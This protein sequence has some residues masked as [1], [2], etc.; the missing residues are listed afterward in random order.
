MIIKWK[1]FKIYDIVIY[2]DSEPYFKKII[3]VKYSTKGHRKD[4]FVHKKSKLQQTCLECFDTCNNGN[5]KKNLNM[6]PPH[7]PLPT[8]CPSTLNST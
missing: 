6:T 2:S 3:V 7:P 4:L 5:I 8:A 1:T